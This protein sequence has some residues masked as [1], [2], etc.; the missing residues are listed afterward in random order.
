MVRGGPVTV[1][2]RQTD[3]REYAIAKQQELVLKP[4]A[5]HGGDGVLLGWQTDAKTWAA[6]LDEAMDEPWV[7]QQRIHPVPETFLTDDGDEQWLLTW[8]AFLVA[9]GLGGFLMRGSRDLD[10]GVVGMS[11]GATGGC[12]FFQRP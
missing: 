3:L 7:L 12:C 9:D 8:G 10:G 1:E 5:L 4:T 6:R 11:T 2:G